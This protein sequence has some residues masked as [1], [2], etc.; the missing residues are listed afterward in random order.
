MPKTLG[1]L[2][3]QNARLRVGK[4]FKKFIAAHPRYRGGGTDLGNI[5][6]NR[7]PYRLAANFAKTLEVFKHI[8]RATASKKVRAYLSQYQKY[9]S[10]YAGAGVAV[11]HSRKRVLPGIV[12][13]CKRQKG[14]GG[15]PNKNVH[16]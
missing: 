9:G 12:R 1:E 3:Y 5:D 7:L 10:R 8:P 14:H 16:L 11:A 15:G 4:A 13:D 2:K 6:V